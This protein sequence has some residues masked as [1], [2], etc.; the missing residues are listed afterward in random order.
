MIKHIAICLAYFIHI[1]CWGRC[2]FILTYN[3]WVWCVCGNDTVSANTISPDSKP[4]C[5]TWLAQKSN[6]GQ[7]LHHYTVMRMCTQNTRISPTS[8]STIMTRIQLTELSLSKC[9]WHKSHCWTK[10]QLFSLNMAPNYFWL[11]PKLKP[12]LEGTRTSEYW[13]SEKCDSSAEDYSEMKFID[14]KLM[15]ISMCTYLVRN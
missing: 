1:K 9:L 3:T 5:L 2:Q 14:L 13:H 11:F 10:L 7:R 4:T 6:Y 15:H 12:P 8:G